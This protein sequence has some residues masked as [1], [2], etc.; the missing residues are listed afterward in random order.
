MIRRDNWAKN[1]A[2]NKNVK[3]Y[4]GAP[5]A[6]SAANAGSYVDAAT[7]GTIIDETRAKYSSFGG[8]CLSTQL[9]RTYS[10]FAL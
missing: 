5:A 7:L 4:I 8:M 1:T 3:I 10:S 9:N 6:P 2:I